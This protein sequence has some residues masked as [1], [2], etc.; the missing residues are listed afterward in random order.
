[1]MK[2]KGRIAGTGKG[3]ILKPT[4]SKVTGGVD[5]WLGCICGEFPAV[6]TLLETVDSRA[7]E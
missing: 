4:N 5:E 7:R 1:M 3:V 2:I 6:G